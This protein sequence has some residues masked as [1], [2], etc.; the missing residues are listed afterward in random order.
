M[1]YAILVQIVIGTQPLVVNGGAAISS[2]RSISL[3]THFKFS[4]LPQWYVV[5]T[6]WYLACVNMGLLLVS[7]KTFLLILGGATQ[8]FL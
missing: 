6:R 8:F 3:L 5:Q 4:P 1:C 2:S 7:V